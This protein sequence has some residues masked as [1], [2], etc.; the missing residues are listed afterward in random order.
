MTG[1]RSIAAVC[2]AWALGGA[3]LPNALAGLEV[4]SPAPTGPPEPPTEV[5]LGDANGDGRVNRADFEV[6]N[7]VVYQYRRIPLERV[8]ALDLDED[9]DADLD[10]LAQLMMDVR[11]REPPRRELRP[12]APPRVVFRDLYNAGL[13]PLSLEA[14]LAELEGRVKAEVVDAY[15]DYFGSFHGLDGTRDYLRAFERYRA[16]AEAAIHYGLLG[17][18]DAAIACDRIQWERPVY[19]AIRERL[20]E[21]RSRRPSGLDYLEHCERRMRA[22]PGGVW[23]TQTRYETELCWWYGVIPYLYIHPARFHVGLRNGRLTLEFPIHFRFAA[24]YEGHRDKQLRDEARIAGA[25]RCVRDW[26]SQYGVDFRFRIDEDAEAEI[27]I[28]EGSHRANARNLYLGTDRQDSS[29]CSTFAH[30]IGHNLGLP[31]EY[32]EGSRS[33][34]ISCSEDRVREVNSLMSQDVTDDL[35]RHRLYPRHLTAIFGPVC[36]P[37]RSNRSGR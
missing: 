5:L 27:T 29:L 20:R 33:S 7:S 23:S 8:R 4:E 11:D 36:G 31:D 25:M 22:A 15:E 37:Y 9:G 34:G 35:W 26:W 21:F 19:D 24:E 28:H 12:A 17:T 2:L 16:E 30:E 32:D 14:K 1:R 18:K 6:F 3:S 13:R 10:D